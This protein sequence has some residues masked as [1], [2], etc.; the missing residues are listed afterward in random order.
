LPS[1]H[2][3]PGITRWRRVRSDTREGTVPATIKLC[4]WNGNGF[5]LRWQGGDFT[6]VI[7]RLNPD[8]LVFQETKTDPSRIPE[9]WAVRE[10]M[11]A[12]GFTHVVWHS[13]IVKQTQHKTDPSRIP[14]P[15]AVREIMFAMG[16]KHVVWY[17]SIVKETQ[18]G[19]M[20]ASKFALPMD[21]GIGHDLIDNDGRVVTIRHPDFTI[22]SP[23]APCTKWGDEQ[24]CPKCA[25]FQKCLG[26]RIAKLSLEKPVLLAGDLNIAP[27][28][29]D[30]TATFKVPPNAMDHDIEKDMRMMKR[31]TISSCKPYKRKW[32]R[33]LMDECKLVDVIA[34]KSDV[35]PPITWARTPAEFAANRGMRVDHGLA[36]DAFLEPTQRPW[37][38]EARVEPKTY[39]SDHLPLTYIN[40]ADK[41]YVPAPPPTPVET[42]LPTSTREILTC[43]MAMVKEPS[44]DVA[45]AAGLHLPPL[46]RK[47]GGMMP[48]L[49]MLNDDN[50]F[51]LMAQFLAGLGKDDYEAP[52][53][54]PVKGPRRDVTDEESR[55]NSD[56]DDSLALA[57]IAAAGTTNTRRQ[58]PKLRVGINESPVDLLCGTGAAHCIIRKD[59]AN[60]LKLPI[61]PCVG[62]EHPSFIM[63]DGHR[64]S[65]EGFVQVDVDIEGCKV[66]MEMY[67]LDKCPFSGLLGWDFRTQYGAH[68][69]ADAMTITFNSRDVR[70]RQASP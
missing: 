13:S 68:I 34:A 6:E 25:I 40:M 56:D 17:S 27:E 60:N 46:S 35:L 11:F 51:F 70:C 54:A 55:A 44:S 9:P 15:W 23:Y 41:E 36:Q 59:T 52:A 49:P 29:V 21:F 28:E 43:A 20:V 16:F 3:K 14:E 38:A 33:Q 19:I 10:T 22:I 39:N 31:D 1:Q 57:I 66:P 62:N 47:L 69:K 24:A 63:A 58:M 12:M 37:T 32:H 2:D 65:P 26:K 67:V 5:V 64:R 42:L 48:L 61:Q 30:C 8:G 53:H 18:H 4:V 45:V 7:N 50:A